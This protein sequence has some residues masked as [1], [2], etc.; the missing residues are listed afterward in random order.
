[1]QTGD[2]PKVRRGIQVYSVAVMDDHSL[3]VVGIMG[4]PNLIDIPW[5]PKL[6]TAEADAFERTVR[7]LVD[8]WDDQPIKRPKS[9]DERLQEA[10]EAR[11]WDL[12]AKLHKQWLERE[13]YRDAS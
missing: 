9:L 6:T 1:M 12:A 5:G 8:S 10:A 2:T 13:E 7:E 11:D 3:V 4:R